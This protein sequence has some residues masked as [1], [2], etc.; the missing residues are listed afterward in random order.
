MCCICCH[1]RL[2]VA[3]QTVVH[4]FATIGFAQQ[5]NLQKPVVSGGIG[6]INIFG[7]IKISS[8]FRE[9][10]V[11]DFPIIA[12]VLNGVVEHLAVATQTGSISLR[13]KQPT[14]N[15]CSFLEILA[16]RILL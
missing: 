11:V 1:F 5:E 15:L 16:Y 13:L 6:R 10:K 8:A 14:N 7:P 12:F 3:R 4:S 2:H 9:V